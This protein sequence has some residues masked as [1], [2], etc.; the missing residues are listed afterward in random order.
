MISDIDLKIKQ[1]QIIVL[2]FKIKKNIKIKKLR[3]QKDYNEFKCT[4]SKR[5]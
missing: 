3:E 1:C 4:K 5:L 2:K